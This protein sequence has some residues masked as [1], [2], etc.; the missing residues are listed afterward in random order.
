VVRIGIVYPL[1]GTIARI[2]MRDSPEFFADYLINDAGG[3]KSLGGAKVELVWGDCQ[4][5]PDLALSEAERL[6]TQENVHMLIGSW[7]SSLTYATQEAAERYK[8]PLYNTDSSSPTLLERNYKYF[9][10]GYPTDDMY[11]MWM[12]D[13]LIDMLTEEGLIDRKLTIGMIVEAALFGQTSRT[14][15]IKYIDKAK[16]EGKVDWEIIE[17]ITFPAPVVDLTPEIIKMKSADPDIVF[18]CPMAPADCVKFATAMIDQN[19]WPPIFMTMGAGFSMFDFEKI[20]EMQ[21][22]SENF[23]ARTTPGT[24]MGEILS[25]PVLKEVHDLWNDNFDYWDRACVS[26]RNQMY[27]IRAVLE[28]AGEI[29][30]GEVGELA[31]F[32]DAIKEGFLRIDISAEESGTYGWKFEREP[33]TGQN[34]KNIIIIHQKLPDPEHESGRDWAFVWPVEHATKDWV[35]PDPRSRGFD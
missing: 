6:I 14:S 5:S 31:D 24:T 9:F 2:V 3:I 27:V 19:W 25:K 17:D 13:F 8:V 4:A 20:Q 10:H 18:A 12:I 33:W 7:W 26:Y 21:E 23:F 35:V 30:G 22:A 34:T 29:T 28:E 16:D 11:G 1:S 32:R 15:W